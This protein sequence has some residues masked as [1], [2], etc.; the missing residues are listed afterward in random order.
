MEMFVKLETP[1]IQPLIV[2][3]KGLIVA[4]GSTCGTKCELIWRMFKNL[5]VCVLL[6]IGKH[7][8][9]HSSIVLPI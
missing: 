6:P 2:D 7:F 8:L 3:P 9:F 1:T 4:V 5:V